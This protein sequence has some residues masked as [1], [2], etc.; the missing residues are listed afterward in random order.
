MGQFGLV[1]AAKADNT[2]VFDIDGDGQ[3]ELLIADRNY[4]RAVRGGP[5][6]TPDR[7][8]LFSPAIGITAFARASRWHRL[9]SW[10]DYFE[11]SAW[12]V[13]IPLSM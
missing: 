7:V 12:L 2:A 5:E 1:K 8:I 9:L 4:V 6:A 11:K 10:I 13:C 3:A